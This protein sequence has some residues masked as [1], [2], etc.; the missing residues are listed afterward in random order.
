MSIKKNI[1][2]Y[3]DHLSDG[4]PPSLLGTLATQISRGKELFSF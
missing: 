3:F 1:Y 4:H 2:V